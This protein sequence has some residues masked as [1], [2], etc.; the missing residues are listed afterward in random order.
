MWSR[1]ARGCGPPRD[2]DPA[3]KVG[4]HGAAGEVRAADERDLTVDHDDLCMQR[5]A[6]R[7]RTGRPVQAERVDARE[8][9]SDCG[10]ERVVLVTFGREGDGHVPCCCGRERRLDRGFGLSRVARQ[11]DLGPRRVDQVDDGCRCEP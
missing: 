11:Q 10:V 2:E 1:I 9:R 6:G 5:G 3:L 4:L 8:R 7:A